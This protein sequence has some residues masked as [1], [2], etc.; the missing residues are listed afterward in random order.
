MTAKCWSWRSCSRLMLHWWLVTAPKSTWNSVNHLVFVF[1]IAKSTPRASLRCNSRCREWK[2]HLSFG[3]C[4][5]SECV[6]HFHVLGIGW[7]MLSFSLNKAEVVL[8]SSSH[9]WCCLHNVLLFPLPVHI[10]GLV[11]KKL[12]QLFLNGLLMLLLFVVLVMIFVLF[13]NAWNTSWQV[14]CSCLLLELHGQRN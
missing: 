4:V 2:N 14:H 11:F 13:W 6:G 8:W 12:V 3:Y 7:K 9:W 10:V 5:N 1:Q